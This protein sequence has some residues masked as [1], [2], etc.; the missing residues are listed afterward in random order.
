MRISFV[1]VWWIG[2]SKVANTQG[3]GLPHALLSTLRLSTPQRPDL[4][5]V[6]CKARVGENEIRLMTASIFVPTHRLTSNSIIQLPAQ[7][8]SRDDNKIHTHRRFG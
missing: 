5:A 4:A 1:R 6:G 8:S 2:R 3:A 7:V